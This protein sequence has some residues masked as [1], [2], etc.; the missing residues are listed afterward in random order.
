MGTGSCHPQQ[1]RDL[2]PRVHPYGAVLCEFNAV[3]EVLCVGKGRALT[4]A[5]KVWFVPFPEHCHFPKGPEALCSFCSTS[6]AFCCSEA[7]RC[8]ASSCRRDSRR[9]NREVIPKL[10][11][12]SQKQQYDRRGI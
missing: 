7:D 10:I 6:R 2:V 12:E 11:P 1:G 5:V 8:S 9:K 4:S 3:L